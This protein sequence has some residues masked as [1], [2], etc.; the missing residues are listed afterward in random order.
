M[1]HFFSIAL[2]GM[3]MPCLLFSQQ[4][5]ISIDVIKNWPSLT[6]YAVSNNGKYVWYQVDR[7]AARVTLTI[8]NLQTKKSLEIEG[9]SGPRFNQDSRYLF[10]RSSEGLH[11]LDLHNYRDIALPDISDF[12]FNND[13]EN[14]KVAYFKKG[15]VY[16]EDAKVKALVNY[17]K[18]NQCFFNNKGTILVLKQDSAITWVDLMANKKTSVVVGKQVEE[19]VLSNEADHIVYSTVSENG[20]CIYKYSADMTAPYILIS[21]S[22]LR[23]SDSIALSPKGLSF[24]SIGDYVFFKYKFKINSVVKDTNIL[25]THMNLWSYKDRFLQSEQLFHIAFNE[26]VYNPDYLFQGVIGYDGSKAILLE[27]ADTLLHGSAGNHYALLKSVNNDGEVYWNESEWPVFK[28]VNYTNGKVIEFLPSNKN[29][30][31][32]QLSPSEKYVIWSDTSLKRTY[33]YEISSGTVKGLSSSNDFVIESDIRYPANISALGWLPHDTAILFNDKYDIWR[34]DPKGVQPRICLTGGFGRKNGISFNLMDDA[35][36]LA[37]KNN[38]EDLILTSLEEQ[39]KRNGFYK[40]STTESSIPTKLSE[41]ECLYYYPELAIAAKRPVKSLNADIYV[42]QHQSAKESVNLVVTKDFKNMQIVSDIYPEKKHNWYSS[43]LVKWMT[44]NGEQRMGILYTPDDLDTTKKYPVIFNFYELRSHELFNYR[45][46]AISV[47]NINIP[48]YLSK[49]YLIFIPDIPRKTGHTGENAL[50]TI[51]SGANYL[52]TRYKWIDKTKMGL[53]GQSY[54]G[55]IVNFVATHS[56]MFAAAQSSAGRTDYISGYGGVGFGGRSLQGA[57]E[58]FQNSLGTTPWEHPEVYIN[59]SAIFGAG[60]TTTP[61][62]IAQG[63][64][65]LAVHESQA[66]ELFTWLRRAKRK[67]WLLQYSGGHIMDAD[68][69]EGLDFTIRQEQFFDHYLMRTPAPSW[70][71]DGIPAKLKGL[72]S[73]LELNTANKVP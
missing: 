43:E 26:G 31:N 66:I 17:G 68:S 4:S 46:P 28:L 48:Y 69:E 35:Q 3:L 12:V 55:T 6:N 23:I 30:S 52:T 54:G 58:A 7:G 18:A 72:K 33:S 50:E 41:C 59:N 53:Q 70:M 57:I 49:G 5:E 21:D 67:V 14:P 22:L 39:T 65:D 47:V 64:G 56:N 61:L 62:L 42:L 45:K 27:N 71:I 8:T 20:T 38:S 25:T 13:I 73:G 32:L 34:I 29:I 36:N 1:R 2:V 37:F 63:S 51:E 10:Y 9:G 15:E 16:V 44:T 24:N 11:K 60:R 40:I 19:V